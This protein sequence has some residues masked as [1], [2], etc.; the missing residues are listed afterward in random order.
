MSSKVKVCSENVVVAEIL[1]FLI[2][3]VGFLFAVGFC[4]GIQRSV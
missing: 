3:M 1:D 4:V 2:A